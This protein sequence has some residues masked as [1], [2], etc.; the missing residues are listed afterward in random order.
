ME[1]LLLYSKLER[2]NNHKALKLKIALRFKNPE[3][4]IKDIAVIAL[5]RSV[6]NSSCPISKNS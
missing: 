3:I 1:Q 5:S 2:K 6:T 4:T